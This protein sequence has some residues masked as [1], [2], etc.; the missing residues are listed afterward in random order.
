MCQAHLPEV[1]LLDQE[2]GAEIMTTMRH[3]VQES[4]RIMKGLENE[5]TLKDEVINVLKREN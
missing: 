5:L 4:E 1:N 3:K 2:E